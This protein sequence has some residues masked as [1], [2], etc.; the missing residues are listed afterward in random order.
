MNRSI[1]WIISCEHLV[2]PV[3]LSLRHRLAS[4]SVAAARSSIFALQFGMLWM[5]TTLHVVVRK[6]FFASVL[7]ALRRC[8]RTLYI[9]YHIRAN[10]NFQSCFLARFCVG[11]AVSRSSTVC[12]RITVLI[13]SRCGN[14]CALPRPQLWFSLRF[15]RA[16]WIKQLLQVAVFCSSTR[17]FLP[18]KKRFAVRIFVRVNVLNHW[19]GYSIWIFS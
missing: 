13:S 2:G 8:Y 6:L 7:F 5:I 19:F 11:S 17:Q 12:I 1:T 16:A 10:H 14:Q 3:C 4:L 18:L 9:R 15:V